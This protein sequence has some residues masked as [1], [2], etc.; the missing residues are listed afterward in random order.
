MT[1]IDSPI[2]RTVQTQVMN[3]KLAKGESKLLKDGMHELLKCRRLSHYLENSARCVHISL[4]ERHRNIVANTESLIA[5]GCS[6]TVT[7]R[8]VDYEPYLFGANEMPSDALVP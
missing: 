5:C 3:V 4:I 7:N 8:S 6:A 1:V 2:I